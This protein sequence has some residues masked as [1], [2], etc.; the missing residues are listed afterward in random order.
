MRKLSVGK[1]MGDIFYEGALQQYHRLPPIVATTSS[2]TI[3]LN[4][5]RT[6]TLVPQ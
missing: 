5:G 1:M 4:Q 2:Y 3:L 6:E